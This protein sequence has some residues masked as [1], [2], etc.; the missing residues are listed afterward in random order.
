[1]LNLQGRFLDFEGCSLLQGR[2]LDLSQMDSVT[3]SVSE[4]GYFFA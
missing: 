2:F 3:N 4:Q 1:M